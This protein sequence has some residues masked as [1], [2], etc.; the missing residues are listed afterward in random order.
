MQWRQLL[1]VF[2]RRR[3]HRHRTQLSAIAMHMWLHDGWAKP[4]R[5]GV[6]VGRGE[7]Q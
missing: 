7:D 1:A 4:G 3:R 6:H 2:H 5:G